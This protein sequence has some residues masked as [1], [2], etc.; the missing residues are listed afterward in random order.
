MDEC[1]QSLKAQYCVVNEGGIFLHALWYGN[2]FKEMEGMRFQQ[3]TEDSFSQ[4]L[5]ERFE[6][7]EAKIF[8]EI[9]K[10][11]SIAFSLKRCSLW[12]RHSSR[13]LY[14]RYDNIP[15]FVFSVHVVV[16]LNHL[17]ERIAPINY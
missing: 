6:I 12:G 5:D 3:Y 7:R 8:S 17:L 11:D 1:R 14:N 4:R 15:F 10:D 2:E 16:S 9:A 13:P